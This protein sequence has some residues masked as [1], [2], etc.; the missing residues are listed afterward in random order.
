MCEDF[1]IGFNKSNE[2]LGKKICDIFNKPH[3]LIHEEKFA[4]GEIN[5]KINHSV[6]NK[7]VYIV[8]SGSYNSVNPSYSL[9]DNLM[10][11][12]LIIDALKRSSVKCVNLIIPVYPYARSDKKDHRGPISSSVVANIFNS[13]QVDRI[14]T[15]DIHSGQIQGFYPKAFDNI[16]CMNTIIDYLKQNIFTE[17]LDNYILCSPDAGSVKRIKAYAQKLCMNYIILEKQRDYTKMNTVLKSI[18][19]GSKESVIGKTV[20]IIDDMADTMGTTISAIDILK[21]NKA[22]NCIVV[23]THGYF[24]GEGIN[25]INNCDFIDK[26]IC[27]NSICQIENI[28]NCNKIN[29]VDISSLL[30]NIINCIEN[31][32]S[33]SK[34]FE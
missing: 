4:N 22:K 18:M 10:S 19:I 25:R 11:T 3:D 1:L 16:Y 17:S 34:L 27:T 14:V 6:R 7:T 2:D 23:V 26:V 29:V 32:E 21:E 15:C 8:A 13:L 12:I 31:G 30:G 5:I 24:S 28:K 9:N 33:I 20:V